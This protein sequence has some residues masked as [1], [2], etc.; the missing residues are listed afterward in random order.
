MFWIRK[1]GPITPK[2]KEKAPS[3]FCRI[4]RSGHANEYC[5]ILGF[6]RKDRK[7]YERKFIND[8]TCKKWI[9]RKKRQLHPD[10]D[11]TTFWYTINSSP[12][13]AMRFHMSGRLCRRPSNPTNTFISPMPSD[14]TSRLRPIDPFSLKPTR[15]GD[16]YVHLVLEDRFKEI[17]HKFFG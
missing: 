17:F 8:R 4:I 13:T 3:G 12:S 1:N 11:T 16:P 6:N 14:G 5:Y 15:D 2:R 9:N 10:A 7:S